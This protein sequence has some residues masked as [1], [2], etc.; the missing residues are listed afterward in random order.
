MCPQYPICYRVLTPNK[1][2]RS[3]KIDVG[4]FS[5]PVTNLAS[6]PESS[7]CHTTE[8]SL[9]PASLAPFSPL[10]LFKKKFIKISYTYHEIYLPDVYNSVIFSILQG[11][12]TIS[13]I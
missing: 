1:I 7:F 6:F 5:S 12:T 10:F 11:Y 8:I 13:T 4:K 9:T 3:V 2:V